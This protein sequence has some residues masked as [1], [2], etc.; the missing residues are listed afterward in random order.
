[1]QTIVFISISSNLDNLN[2]VEFIKKKQ[3]ITINKMFPHCPV[4][5]IVTSKINMT[6]VLYPA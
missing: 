1:M 3:D 2:R 4:A 6:S 5:L